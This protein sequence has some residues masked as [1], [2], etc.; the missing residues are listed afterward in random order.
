MK[1]LIDPEDFPFTEDEVYRAERLLSPEADARQMA[2]DIARAGREAQAAR[3]A[4]AAARARGSR[5]PTEINPP[6]MLL[7]GMYF[8]QLAAVSP[9]LEERVERY[10]MAG[11]AQAR[12]SRLRNA[13]VRAGLPPR[14]RRNPRGPV[15]AR[16]RRRCGRRGMVFIAGRFSGRAAETQSPARHHV[17]LLLTSELRLRLR[18]DGDT[19]LAAE[20]GR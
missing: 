3:I 9:E 4:A 12:A 18:R 19:S 1:D 8:A 13:M 14:S 5:N 11:R 10:R 16:R 17:S 2:A 6:V 15:Q 7:S 20:L